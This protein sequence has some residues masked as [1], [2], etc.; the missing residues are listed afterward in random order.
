[1]HSIFRTQNIKSARQS[2]T[3]RLLQYNQ[4]SAAFLFSLF[5]KMTNPSKNILAESCLKYDEFENI[6]HIKNYT[7]ISHIKTTASSRLPL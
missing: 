7:G 2:K 1:M 6:P 5:D 4:S 3:L